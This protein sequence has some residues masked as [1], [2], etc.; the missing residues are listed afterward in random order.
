MSYN[1]PILLIV[2]NRVDKTR[3]LLNIIE[4]IKPK[5]LFISADG[6]KQKNED[7]KNCKEVRKI[8]DNINFKCDLNKKF[9]ETNKG[10][11]INVKESINWF[12][13][14]IDKGI[15]LED[16]CLPSESFFIFCENLLNKYYDNENIMHIN[17]TNLGINYEDNLKESYFFS[18]L[19]HVWGWA[20][21]KR[22]WIHYEDNFNN[23]LDYKNTGKIL[24]YFVDKKITKWMINYYDKSFK[25]IDNIWSTNWSFSILKNNGLCISP[26]LNLVK[27]IGFDGSGTSSKSDLFRKFSEVNVDH[28]EE[29]LHPET[30]IY[31]VDYDK[32]AFNEKISKID[33]RANFFNK[34]KLYFKRKFSSL[35]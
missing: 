17:G 6:P 2:Y 35:V 29:I 33:P 14:N 10:L 30:L 22:A 3:Q 7:I 1:I 9:N 25:G 19:N 23:Y 5:K 27:N 26:K 18:K 15:I 21:W 31:N 28:F 13:S 24:K 4:K 12:F 16:D 11:K 8:F 32:L 20:T 34:L